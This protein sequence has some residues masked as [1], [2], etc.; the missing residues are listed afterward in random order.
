M[1]S[2]RA[3]QNNMIPGAYGSGYGD[4]SLYSKED[5]SPYHLEKE[6]RQGPHYNQEETVSMRQETAR[7]YTTSFLSRDR[8]R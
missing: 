8:K 3:S 7:E 2:N 4:R 5:F 1:A 6:L